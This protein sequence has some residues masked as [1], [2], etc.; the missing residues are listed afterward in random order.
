MVG[1]FVSDKNNFSH[2][3]VNIYAKLVNKF[4]IVFLYS[5][6]LLNI[7]PF[8]IKIFLF[9]INLLNHTSL[10][11]RKMPINKVIMPY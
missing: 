6:L 7:R 11:H 1:K 5:S 8:M 10:S 9:K 4:H 3:W 2:N